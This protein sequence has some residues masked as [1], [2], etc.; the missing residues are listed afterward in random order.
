MAFLRCIRGID[1]ITFWMIS[2][3][4][5]IATGLIAN[6]FGGYVWAGAAIAIFNTVLTWVGIESG[7]VT[8]K[9]A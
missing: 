7:N 1:K 4:G 9:A 3:I 8:G 6:Y 2:T 5:N